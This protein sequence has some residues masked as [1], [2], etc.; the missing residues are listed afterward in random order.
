MHLHP[1]TMYARTLPGPEKTTLIMR[2]IVQF[3]EYGAA[4]SKFGLIQRV[5]GRG[6]C[7]LGWISS[8]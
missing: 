1:L 6:T 8:S 7:I 5:W 3:P 4:V 2:I